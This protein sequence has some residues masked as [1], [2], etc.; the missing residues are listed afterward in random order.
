MIGGHRS[1]T[2]E[3]DMTEIHEGRAA[4]YRNRAARRSLHPHAGDAG[5]H[6]CQ[7]RYFRRL[8]AR[9]DRSDSSVLASRSAKSRTVTVAIEAMNF[10]KAVYVGDLVSVYGQSGAG[11]THL[12]HCS[13]RSLGRAPQ[14]VAVD[15]GD[16]RQLHLRLDRRRRPAAGG[17]AGWCDTNLSFTGRDAR[18]RH[19]R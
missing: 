13:S 2:S 7:W 9:P 16:R 5:R 15:P 4:R 3:T 14:G 19:G 17:A 10:R 6:Q 1:A 8:A 11:R 12:D 18:S